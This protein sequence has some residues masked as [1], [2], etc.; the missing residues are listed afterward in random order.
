MRHPNLPAAGRGPSR[1]TPGVG[2]PGILPGKDEVN[3]LVHATGRRN[4]GSPVF[5]DPSAFAFIVGRFRS[6]DEDRKVGASSGYSVIDGFRHIAGGK[7]FF[8]SRL[9][10]T[11]ARLAP[12]S[13]APIDR[14]GL[15]YRA[16]EPDLDVLLGCQDRLPVLR[17]HLPRTGRQ[18]NRRTP[19]L[20]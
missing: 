7:A 16:G 3:T 14:R 20:E 11:A 2:V 4:V 8:L 13:G 9:H 1:L 5:G 10:T 6:R 15:L 18:A 12:G 17:G 19:N